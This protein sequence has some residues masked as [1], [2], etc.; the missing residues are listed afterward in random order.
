MVIN[1]RQMKTVTVD[2]L[3]DGVGKT[4]IIT[5]IEKEDMQGAC[6]LFAHFTLKPG[7]SIGRH[8]H[9]GEEELY[10]IISGKGMVDDNGVKK[11]V[12]AGDAT[13]TPSGCFHAIENCGEDELE[14]LAC[15]LTY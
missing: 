5:L 8:G 7:C 2:K 6:R 11:I 9:E 1:A 4:E 3:R 10:Y 12:Q 15:V 14:F 13:I